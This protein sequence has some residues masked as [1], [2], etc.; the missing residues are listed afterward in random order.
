MNACDTRM[1]LTAIMIIITLFLCVYTLLLNF[2]VSFLS[3]DKT[4]PVD[5]HTRVLDVLVYCMFIRERDGGEEI[6]A[7]AR[8]ESC[9]R[10]FM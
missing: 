6:S 5:K 3:N 4:A 1:H 9:I 8:A 10:E 2:M 7:Y